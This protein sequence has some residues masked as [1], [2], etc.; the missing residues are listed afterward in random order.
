M[1]Q[2]QRAFA[3]RQRALKKKHK[4]L[5]KGYV[6]E[7]SNTGVFIRKPDQ[8]SPRRLSSFLLFAI[9]F[10]FAF[11]IASFVAIGEDQYLAEL[12]TLKAGNTRQQVGAWIMQLDPV[13]VKVSELLQEF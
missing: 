3:K 1:E 10:A 2:S 12:E 9:A 6:T 13:T 4:R 7:L 11:K 5:A 8:K